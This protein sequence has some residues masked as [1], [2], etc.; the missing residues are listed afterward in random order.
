MDF[1]FYEKID[2]A[3]HEET[4]GWWR[5]Y[6]RVYNS[7]CHDYVYPNP[8]SVMAFIENHDTDRFLRDGQDVPALKQ[9]LALLLTIKRIPQLYYGTEILMNG[10]KQIT[11][12]N[13][14]KDFPGGFPGDQHNAFTPEGRTPAQNDMFNWLSAL[15]HWRQGNDVIIKGK[16]T[17]FIPK[18][19]IYV[20]AR[21]YQGRHALTIINGTTHQQTMKLDRYKEA[22]GNATTARDVPTGRNVNLANG[23]LTLPARGTLVLEF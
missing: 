2:S 11:D 9:A 4:D 6:N 20:I 23:E 15:L 19:G 3:K 13:V 8:S 16:M 17:Q 10:T 22:L 21:E 1:S 5:G 14:R 18:D 12:G 7:L